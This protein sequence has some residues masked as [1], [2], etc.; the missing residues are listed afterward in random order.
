MPHMRTLRS[1]LAL[2]L[3]VGCQ[4]AQEAPRL[5]LPL[6][7]DESGIETTTNDLGFD[8][9]LSEA[10]MAVRDFQFTTAGELH[11]ASLSQKLWS[12]LIPAALAH[13]GHYEGGEV[14]GE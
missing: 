11:T 8:I 14:I 10:R 4:P 13:P 2:F 12:F 7:V 6:V 3:L 9:T 5:E 1:A